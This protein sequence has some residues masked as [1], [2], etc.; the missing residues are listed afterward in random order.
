MG[1]ASRPIASLAVSDRLRR[2]DGQTAQN[3]SNN[4]E[5]ARNQSTPSRVRIGAKIATSTYAAKI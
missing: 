2:P 4:V 5:I 3:M 1:S